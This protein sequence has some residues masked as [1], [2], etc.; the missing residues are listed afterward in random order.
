MISVPNI[1][2]YNIFAT[3][4]QPPAVL[5]NHI[6]STIHIMGETSFLGNKATTYGHKHEPIAMKLYEK[7]MKT[8][9]KCFHV[10]NCGLIINSDTPIVRA[11][12]DGVTSCKCCGKGLLEIKCPYSK[13]D[14]T[15]EEIAREGKYHLQIGNDGKIH[16]KQTSPWYTQVQTQLGVAEYAWCDFVIFT[17]RRPYITIERIC[18]DKDRIERELTR[19]LAFYD[20]F[21]LP[22]LIQK[23]VELVSL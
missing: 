12:P 21:V 9:H 10:K 14:M 5:S 8:K 19:G 3:K 1:N 7:S 22:K 16:L 20:K 13:Q 15:A 17:K 4:G 23:S 2:F 11:S 6:T 18:F